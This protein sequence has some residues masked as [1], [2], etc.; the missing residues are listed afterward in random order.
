MVTIDTDYPD[1]R[2]LVEREAPLGFAR[3]F[4]LSEWLD[5]GYSVS[6][7]QG[8]LL[9]PNLPPLP[10]FHLG[11][12]SRADNRFR[13]S[14]SPEA[15]GLRELGGRKEGFALL[16]NESFEADS[17]SPFELGAACSALVAPAAA[18]LPLVTSSGFGLYLVAE[19]PLDLRRLSLSSTMATLREAGRYCLSAREE[20]VLALLG[21]LGFSC[22]SSEQ[23][24]LCRRGEEHFL[25]SFAG[26]ELRLSYGQTR[27]RLRPSWA[28]PDLASLL[29]QASSQLEQHQNYAGARQ[30]LLAAVTLDPESFDAQL[31]LGQ[32]ELAEGRLEQAELRLLLASLLRPKE[33]YALSLLADCYAVAD[34]IPQAIAAQERL[35]VLDPENSTAREGLERLR[36]AL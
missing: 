9:R 35:L 11:E 12:F 5:P 18:F 16:A 24:V 15:Q 27:A 33:A 32:V 1:Y 26:D 22:Q 6:P 13:W 3:H 25:W 4:A 17:L 8:E 10:V 20:W 29:Q 30:A 7:H 23:G 21:Q 34:K 2:S 36:G 31:Q 14:E 19:A 28:P